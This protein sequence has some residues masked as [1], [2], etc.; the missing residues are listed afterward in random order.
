M[1]KK[2]AD[3][4]G[5]TLVE[6]IVVLVILGILASLLVPALTGYI[7]KAKEKQLLLLAKSL[8]TATQTVVSETYAKGPFSVSGSG[9][10]SKTEHMPSI[11]TIISLSEMKDWGN[12]GK[13][14]NYSNIGIVN[15]FG[16]GSNKAAAKCHFKALVSTDGKIKKFVVCDGTKWAVLGE[17]GFEVESSY[18]NKSVKSM[19][20]STFHTGNNLYNYIIIGEKNSPAFEDLFSTK[21]APS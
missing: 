7:D 10:N 15:G 3:R 16:Y 21:H 18:D 1:K 17:N 12:S 5:F 19:Q 9:D 4:K 2:L 11:E 6:L 8:H 14:W 20:C 13:D